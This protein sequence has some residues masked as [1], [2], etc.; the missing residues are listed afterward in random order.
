VLDCIC[1]ENVISMI[2]LLRA[3][4]ADMSA[5]ISLLVFNNECPL[6]YW[7]CY[8]S[9]SVMSPMQLS[10]PT[11][12]VFCFTSNRSTFHAVYARGVW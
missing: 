1:S 4:S 11:A 9:L 10:R 2:F 7:L 6:R 3:C 5:S 12:L 8:G